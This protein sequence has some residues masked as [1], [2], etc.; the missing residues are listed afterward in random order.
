MPDQPERNLCAKVESAISSW[1]HEMAGWRQSN[2]DLTSTSDGTEAD[3]YRLANVAVIMAAL[4]GAGPHGRT[5]EIELGKKAAVNIAAENILKFLDTRSGKDGHGRYLNR[6]A[7]DRIVGTALRKPTIRNRVD[8]AIEEAAQLEGITLDADDMHFA[9]LELNGT[10]ISYFGA[11]CLVLKADRV[12]DD[13]LVLI[14]NSYDLTVSPV[15][16]RIYEPSK[17]NKTQRQAR[18]ELASWIGRWTADAL[19][20]AVVKI[21]A[22]RPPQTRRLTTG[23]VSDGVL[24]DEDYIE[25][26]LGQDFVPDDIAEIRLPATDAALEAQIGDRMQFGP[27]PSATEMLWRARRRDVYRAAERENVLIRVVTSTGRERR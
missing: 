25:I 5:A 13:T 24:T 1:G 8:A 14:R 7:V 21:L 11:F 12:P 22:D 23:Q 26:I 10:G 9:A 27:T 15:V 20:M 17:Y 2:S 6:P 3:G 19:S 4:A 16:E 18:D